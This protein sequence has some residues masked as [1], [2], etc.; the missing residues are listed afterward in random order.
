MGHTSHLN[1][2]FGKRQNGYTQNSTEMATMVSVFLK[3]AFAAIIPFF[4]LVIGLA[5]LQVWALLVSIFSGLV[6]GFFHIYKLYKLVRDD[7]RE[8]KKYKLS[9]RIANIKK[10]D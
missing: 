5:T 8:Q 3:S 6:I 2:N 7:V 10:D 1:D 9:K 4:F